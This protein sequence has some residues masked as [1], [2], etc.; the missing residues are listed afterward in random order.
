M[1]RPRILVVDDDNAL[2]RLLRESLKDSYEIFDTAEPTE[3][4]SLALDLQPDCI[5][6]DLLMPGLTGFE[7]CKTISSLSLTHTIPILVVSGNPS[8]QYEDL[9][10]H[11]GAEDYFEKPIDFVRLR[12]RLHELTDEGLRTARPELRLKLQVGIELRGL[13]RY[14]R[15]FYEVTATE[16]VSASGFRCASAVPLVRKSVVEVYLRGGTAKRRVG[17]A[18]VVYALQS[19]QDRTQYGFHFTQRP[20]EWVL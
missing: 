19:G 1:N 17:R 10:S 9:C 7:L 14:G 6:L 2:R 8:A 12:V 4:L 20:C 15:A 13:N 16:D 5:L 18:E 3:A 11:L